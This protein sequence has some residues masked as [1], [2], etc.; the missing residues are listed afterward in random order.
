MQKI[1]FKT[2]GCRTNIY[3]TQVMI[4]QILSAN[5]SANKSANL[6]QST[7]DF[8]ISANENDADII[9]INSCTVT[10]NADKSL[11][12]YISHIRKQNKKIFFTGC[13][14]DSVGRTLFDKGAIFG[15]FGHSKK[16]QIHS[17]LKSQNPFFVENDLKAVDSVALQ[18]LTGRTRAFIKVQEGCDFK[19]SYC[20]IPQV[21]GKTRSL[22][23]DLILEQIRTLTNQG[24]SEFVLSGTNLGSYGKDLPKDSRD[25][26]PKLIS[27]ISD[28]KGVKRIRLGS[29]EPSQIN[30]EFLEILENPILERHL[31]IAIQHTDDA[32]L[33]LMN[34][35]NRFEK[36]LRLFEIL[37]NKGFALGSDFIV[38]HPN[39][40]DEVFESAL[41]KLESMPLTHIHCFIFSPRS[42]TKSALMQNDTP[43]A[44]AKERLKRVVD[45]IQDKNF[46]FRFAKAK[47][48]ES[49]NILVE[50]KK[51]DYF[52]GFDEYFNKIAIKS[53]AN[54][55][56]SWAKINDYQA[57]EELNYAEI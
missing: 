19:C 36:D 18:T 4:S 39:E 30:S 42:G 22:N 25:T 26:L 5:Q 24:V 31:H 14:L 45:L 52:Y 12:E 51:G 53:S 7:A 55:S 43:K 11:K 33:R 46:A 41:K 2:F 17:L 48:R 29:L 3:D 15:A 27:D 10:N 8:E 20:I 6:S 49:L 56:H 9:V 23:R 38:A 16:A 32:M 44:V 57:K 54:L 28:I 37:A 21:R 47:T 50:S 35:A 1:F 40:S 34:R 13:A